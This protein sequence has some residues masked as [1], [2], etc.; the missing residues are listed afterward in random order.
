MPHILQFDNSGQSRQ[1][2]DVP[3]GKRVYF[4]RPQQAS[5]GAVTVHD[6]QNGITYTIP[7]GV[8]VYDTNISGDTVI[9]PA[10]IGRENANLDWLTVEVTYPR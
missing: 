2:I 1:N 3:T 10:F 6:F 5:R 4:V 9:C 8:S 7:D